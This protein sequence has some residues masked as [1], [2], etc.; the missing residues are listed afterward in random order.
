MFTFDFYDTNR[1]GLL[2]LEESWPFCARS[3]GL[4]EVRSFLFKAVVARGGF[5]ALDTKRN[6]NPPSTHLRQLGFAWLLMAHP[7]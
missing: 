4:A 2:E 3:V 7:P 1:S 6:P 5:V